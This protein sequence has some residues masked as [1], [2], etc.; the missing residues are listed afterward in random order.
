VFTIG[1]ANA[2]CDVLLLELGEGYCC[3]ALLKLDERSFRQIRYIT[4]DEWETAE[5][6]VQILDEL[7]NESCERAIVCSAFPQSLLVPTQF[8]KGR[9]PFLDTIYDMPSQK[10]FRDSIPEWQMITTYSM[11]ASIFNLI[12]ERF[13]NVQFFHAY[14]PV[15]KI[16]NGFTA[17][18]QVDIHF[19][20]QHFRVVVKRDKQ[21]ELLQTYPYKTPLD[22]TY[23]LLKICY[24]F[25]LKQ[26]EI[27]LVVSGLI[28]KDSAMY[29]ELHNYFLNLHFAEAPS[30]SVPGN[31]FPQHYLTSL[32]NLAACVS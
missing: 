16:Y 8:S 13:S 19:S 29:N 6:L 25:H 5:N 21:V 32:Y 1:N 30:Y 3:Y 23:Y 4:L 10:Y 27:F 17:P 9:H 14:T 28:D 12:A 22:V 31:D 15:L 18:D 7:K 2:G 24:E 11:P 20:T 26:S